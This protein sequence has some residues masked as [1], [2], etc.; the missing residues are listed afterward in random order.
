MY[1]EK[2]L[3]AIVKGNKIMFPAGF[4]PEN[5]YVLDSSR[6]FIDFWYKHCIKTTD[7]PDIYEVSVNWGQENG[8][9]IK[10]EGIVFE[11]ELKEQIIINNWGELLL[12]ECIEY[13]HQDY[14]DYRKIK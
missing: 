5:L 4:I 9:I 11:L 7:T 2:P 14:D 10:V 8:L 6:A 13:R 12:E 1:Q 3:H